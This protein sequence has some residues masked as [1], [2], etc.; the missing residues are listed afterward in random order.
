MLI[1]EIS[2][3]II[4][5]SLFMSWAAAPAGA[6]YFKIYRLKDGS[7]SDET[8]GTLEK[9]ILLCETSD[10]FMSDMFYYDNLD[11]EGDI[12]Y[13]I[14]AMSQISGAAPLATLIVTPSAPG[15]D[16]LSSILNAA[17]ASANILFRNKIWAGTAYILRPRT[18][19]TPCSCYSP[20]RRTSNNPDCTKCYG[21]G[22]AGGFYTPIPIRYTEIQNVKRR[23]EIDED[24]PQAVHAPILTVPSVPQVREKDLLAT[25]KYG[26]LIITSSETR[27]VQESKLPT[28]LLHTVKIAAT[29]VANKFP[30]EAAYPVVTGIRTEQNEV[31]VSGRNLVSVVGSI[32]LC[33]SGLSGNFE[34]ISLGPTDLKYSAV[35]RLVF[36]SAVPG[37]SSH[38]IRYIL[39]LNNIP[40]EGVIV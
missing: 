13:R 23:K 22:F 18:N 11:A 2:P 34:Y 16:T 9:A 38:G 1:T 37:F 10:T 20:D 27:S 25:S 31:I 28:S 32:S 29:H 6:S 17:E 12:K 40:I 24:S 35:D 39:F 8:A 21:T 19:G 5:R 26:L 14:D 7:A 15:S 4:T 36:K 33:I 30:I 3:D